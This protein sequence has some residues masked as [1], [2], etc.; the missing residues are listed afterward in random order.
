MGRC[1]SCGGLTV[2]DADPDAPRICCVSCGR[3]ANLA[4]VK[5]DNRPYALQEK[6]GDPKTRK[7]WPPP[8]YQKKPRSMK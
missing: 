6:E 7:P 8:N 3:S 1:G 5:H 4:Y 2:L